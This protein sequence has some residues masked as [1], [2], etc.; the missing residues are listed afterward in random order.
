M[1]NIREVSPNNYALFNNGKQL[2]GFRKIERVA[3]NSNFY[4]LWPTTE[5]F[6]LYHIVK[7]N[8]AISSNIIF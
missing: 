2:T 8:F 5:Y 3:P 7:E 4:C 1:A 6:H